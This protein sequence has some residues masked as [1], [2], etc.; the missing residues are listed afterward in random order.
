MRNVTSPDP[1]GTYGTGRI[2]NITAVLDR[3]VTLYGEPRLDLNAGP[4]AHA[5]YADGNGTDEL[6]FQYSVMPGDGAARLDYA[7]TGALS[8]PE[9]GYVSYGDGR[10]A[11]GLQVLLPP[12]APGSLGAPGSEPI[13]VIGG[14]LPILRPNGTALDDSVSSASGYG[15]LRGA[16]GID[17]L[18]D[19]GGAYALVAA[20]AE[21][22]RTNPN[23]GGVQLI[24]IH[25]NGTL[26]PGGLDRDPGTNRL[27][28][29]AHVAA[30]EMGGMP[31]AL[32]SGGNSINLYDIGHGGALSFNSSETSAG[33]DA[34]RLTSVTGVSVL[35]AY[36]RTYALA[37]SAPDSFDNAY[38]G[39]QLAR[40]LANGTLSLNGSATHGED[41]FLLDGVTAIEALGPNDGDAAA[42]TPRVLVT[43]PNDNAVQLVSIHPDGTLSVNGSAKN[44]TLG[45]DALAG[46]SSAAVFGT[47][48]GNR[49][50]A[51]AASA[52]GDT[53]QL[54]RIHPDGTL[55]A[56]GSAFSGTTDGFD[57]IGHPQDVDVFEMGGWPYALVSSYASDGVQLV[58]ID[59]DGGALVAAGS[60]RDEFAGFKSLGSAAGV[61]VFDAGNRTY[62]L[63]AS[64]DDHG[65]QMVR[66]SPASAV[67]ASSPAG[68]GPHPIGRSINIT[69][70]FDERVVLEDPSRP[71]SLLLSLDGDTRAAPYLDGN[72]T[73]EFVFNYTVRPGDATPSGSGLEYAHAGA[74]VS[75]GAITDLREE[76]AD[77]ELPRPGADGSLSAARSIAIDGVRPYAVSV[78][79]PNAS[80]TYAPGDDIHITVEFSEAV[81][82]ADTPMLEMALDGAIR[83]VNYSHGAGTGM[84]TFVYTV[85]AGDETA[86]LTYA[87]TGAL[88]L[89]DGGISDAPGNA[90][91]GALPDQAGRGLLP[92][93]SG[94]IAIDGAGPRVASVTEAEPGKGAPYRAGEKVGIAVDFGETVTPSA[95]FNSSLRLA[96]DGEETRTA[97]Y[98]ERSGDGMALVH[99]YT[100]QPGDSANP[101]DYDGP[102]ALS[103]SSG[104]LAD[105]LDNPATVLALP[106]PDGGPT[107]AAA[108][109][110]I[111]TERP[112]ILSVSSPDANGTYGVGSEI[113][114]TVSFGEDVY[115]A[116]SPRISLE[117]G[118]TGGRASYDSGGGSPVLV[119]S[120]P[121]LS[122]DLA[123]DLEYA[124]AGALDLNGGTIRDEAGNPAVLRLPDPG[125]HS[126]LGGS[127]DIVV[128]ATGPP[129]PDEQAYVVS[130][131]SRDRGGSYYDGSAVNITV[132]FSRAVDVTGMPL[133]ALSTEPPRDAVYV[134]GS[135]AAAPPEEL[136][137]RYE[138]REGDVADRLNYA[139]TGALSLNGGTITHAGG[140]RD[141][142]LE[143]PPVDSARSLRDSGIAI[144]TG[145][146]GTGGGGTGGGGTDGGTGTQPPAPPSPP[147]T[148]PMCSLGLGAADLA[149]QVEP[150]MYSDPVRQAVNNTGSEEFVRVELEA[151]PWYID[152]ASGR[153]DP[154]ARYLPS[155]LTVMGADGAAGTFAPL[156]NGTA[157]AQGLA[158][159]D[160]PVQLWFKIDL[161]SYDR[162]NATRL[163]QSIAYTAECASPPPP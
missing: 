136:A 36:G 33:V 98:K 64:Q 131:L 144:G 158:G 99:S 37:S 61:A 40:I 18:E 88:S 47:G 70:A 96:L 49:T 87:G 150:G 78:S 118:G 57:T 127:K 69:V 53:I 32:V 162:V 134:A 141:A 62:A 120:Y 119:F 16:A 84:L 124:G 115:V 45:F 68:A 151:T 31:R 91:I 121:V 8:M 112:S 72:G 103:I 102:A 128:D 54:I 92:A 15:A 110:R 114:I 113:N 59:A 26:S 149:V 95:G 157:V 122:G 12:G 42:D 129:R 10:M 111:D 29:A 143:L 155:S 108:G 125:S 101:L 83:S 23:P 11:A 27:Y 147:P 55:A 28:Q 145:I 116:G 133:L 5:A 138:V 19:G 117:T 56:A 30:F 35:E 50:H 90:A 67:G 41:G 1:G 65:V 159:G 82:V 140:G 6:T 126:S 20:S 43:S 2:V 39:L 106:G 81:R 100:V 66:L 71:P 130:V 76:P 97:W 107:L 4:D 94:S 156:S 9:G 77:L 75:R 58:R 135:A 3:P 22:D 13:A 89:D 48:D 38:D 153:P 85:R 123:S 25:P 139:G 86:D 52:L 7:G 137:F 163:V 63:V 44:G 104:S 132:A 105:A 73:A 34:D 148:P 24:R 161:T 14:P 142:N 79:S 146:R 46:A 51:V 80:G 74:L 93:G 60:A 109:I 160:P 154:G 17:V 152:P 21:P